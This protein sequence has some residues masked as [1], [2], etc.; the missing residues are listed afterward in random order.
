MLRYMTLSLPY[1][2]K[3]L[4]FEDDAETDKFLTDHGAAIYTN[5]TVAPAHAHAKTWHRARATPLE[6]RVWDAKGAHAACK[7]GMDKYRVV[8][9]KG[10]VD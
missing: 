9:L 3:T 1:L 10:Q 5:P 7:K 6:Q 8:D 4:A 2:T